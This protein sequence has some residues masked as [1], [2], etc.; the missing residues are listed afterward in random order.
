M[1]I[2]IIKP[3]EFNG[4][5][6]TRNKV[7]AKTAYCDH[8]PIGRWKNKV[9]AVLVYWPLE[10]IP[11]GLQVE[12]AAAN[13]FVTEKIISDPQILEV[14]QIVSRWNPCT[15]TWKH[16]PLLNPVPAG[17]TTISNTTFQTSIGITSLVQ[18]WITNREVNFGVLV[19]FKD[20]LIDDNI[21]S[22][23]GGKGCDSRFWPLLQIQY[24]TPQQIT[25]VCE[26]RTIEE[27]ITVETSR[28]KN[29]TTAVDIMQ[30]N[31][32][33][34]IYNSGVHP[35]CAQLQISADGAS[36]INQTNLE[37]I[38]PKQSVALTANNMARFARIEYSSLNSCEDT[39]FIITLQ[40]CT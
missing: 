15:T 21:I 31:Y 30:F 3:P 1:P 19:K 4:Y 20:P 40:G 22:I 10:D 29:Y 6:T 35:G 9:S 38:A 5:I 39:I 13:F 11:F 8:L 17:C 36:W 2:K 23:Y 12:S 26:S 32:T 33:Y 18:G 27:T 16:H 25:C 7:A 37:I 14:Y 24:P 28:N 34:L